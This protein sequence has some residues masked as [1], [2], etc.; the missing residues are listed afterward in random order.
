MMFWSGSSALAAESRQD[1]ALRIMALA[2]LYAERCKDLKVDWI[3]L[4]VFL[5]EAGVNTDRLDKPPAVGK[6][7]ALLGEEAKR[8]KGTPVARLCQR[9]RADFGARSRIR[10]NILSDGPGAALQNKAFKWIDKLVD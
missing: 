2:Q 6:L 5:D 3:R 1:K 8:L 10:K 7:A 9:A 4:T